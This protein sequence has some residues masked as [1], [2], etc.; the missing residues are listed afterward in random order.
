MS[1]DIDM[2]A[3]TLPSGTSLML[4]KVPKLSEESNKSSL[5]SPMHTSGSGSPPL[6]RQRTSSSIRRLGQNVPFGVFLGGGGGGGG[7][8]SFVG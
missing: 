4:N 5:S 6:K 2:I 7:E 1:H 8:L 3:S